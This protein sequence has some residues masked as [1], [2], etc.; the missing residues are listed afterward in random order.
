MRAEYNGACSVLPGFPG[1][2]Q[3]MNFFAIGDCKVQTGQPKMCANNGV[4]HI[5]SNTGTRMGHCRTQN[6][7]CS[8][9]LD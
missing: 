8:C 9:V 4:C 1:L 6:N 2:L 3:K 7:V 5:S